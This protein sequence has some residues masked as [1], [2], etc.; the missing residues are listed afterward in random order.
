MIRKHLTYA[1]VTATFALVL[2]AGTGAVYAAGEIGSR[3]LENNSVRTQDLKDRRG[4]TGGD[5]RRNTLGGSEI[6]E[7]SLRLPHW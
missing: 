4:V 6:E 5:V 2:A 7:E 1:N 3:D